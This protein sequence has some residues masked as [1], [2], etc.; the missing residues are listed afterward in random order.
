MLRKTRNFAPAKRPRMSKTQLKK[1][2]SA[3]SHDQ[4]VEL[5][6]EA[7]SARKEVKEYFEY[8]LA[9]DEN[10]LM[11]KFRKEVTKE[12]SRTR[13]GGYSK[14]RISVLKRLIGDFE[15]F[16]PSLSSKVDFMMFIFALGVDGELRL[17]YPPAL[18]KG[19]EWIMLR[20]VDMAEDNEDAGRILP[21]VDAV[22]TADG[23]AHRAFRR[24][25]AESLRERVSRI[26]LDRRNVKQ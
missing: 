7:Y 11:E 24:N 4:L 10:R 2:L 15:S 6:L 26:R 20:A 16:Q 14:A 17:W 1:E 9:P 13:R 5:I 12:L 8:F 18:E 3:L 25:L 22:L 21:L 19:L 23:Y